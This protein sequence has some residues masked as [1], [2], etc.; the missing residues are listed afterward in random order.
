MERAD[1]ARKKFL[2][3]LRAEA[4]IE[5][6]KGYVTAQAKPAKADKN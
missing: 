4:F 2:A 1:E 5:I 6:T 3:K